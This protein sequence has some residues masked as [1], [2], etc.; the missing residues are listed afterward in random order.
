MVIGRAALQDF[1]AV[2]VGFGSKPE[3]LTSS[4][5]GPLYLLI[6]DIE[7]TF[8]GFAFVPG[9]DIPAAQSHAGT[10]PFTA[11]ANDS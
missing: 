8:R 3:E 11:F 2:H 5:T 9:T 10:R 4:I 1:D 7:Q 6:A